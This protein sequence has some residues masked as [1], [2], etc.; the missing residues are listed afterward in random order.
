MHQKGQEE[1]PFDNLPEGTYAVTIFHKIHSPLLSGGTFVN[2]GKYTLVFGR[3]NAHVVQGR[4]GKSVQQ[5]IKQADEK[6]KHDIVMTVPYDEKTLTWKTDANGQAKPLFNI[7]SNVHRIRLI[8]ILC[9]YLHQAAGYPVK[10]TWLQAIKDGFFTCWLGLT[11]ALVSKFL[12]EMSEE[13]A[14]GTYI[15]EDTASRAQ[16]YR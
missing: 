16:E 3:E 13:S 7:A 9:D 2:E 6:N 10:K 4:T 14:A 12:P 5:I 11:F 1:L 8:K 15:D